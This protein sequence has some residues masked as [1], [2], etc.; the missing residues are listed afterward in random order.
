MEFR[1]VKREE[2]V[3]VI[4][5]SAKSNS[6]DIVLH[7]CCLFL[8]SVC[9]SALD[10]FFFFLDLHCSSLTITSSAQKKKKNGAFSDKSLKKAI[11]AQILT[12]FNLI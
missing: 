8:F 6:R 2:G 12:A 7:F 10:S 4:Q 11:K 5:H 3:A 1:D 9:Q